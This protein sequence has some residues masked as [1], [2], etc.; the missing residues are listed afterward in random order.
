MTNIALFCI[1]E[2][3]KNWFVQYH[4]FLLAQR[5]IKTLILHSN[6]VSDQ[7]QIFINSYGWLPR[8]QLNRVI[9]QCKLSLNI[10]PVESFSYFTVEALLLGSLPI[11]SPC[12]KDNLQLSGALVVYNTDSPIEI[13]KKI[14][15]LEE[16][17]RERYQELLIS[18]Q[19]SVRSL[20]AAQ[21][22]YLKVMLE[23]LADK[24]L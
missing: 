14:I 18:S 16:L 6:V 3:R 7:P 1:K 20:I 4:G 10:F 9:Q 11:I 17:P 19:N 23:T 12:V 24:K 15:E 22:Q 13:S 5:K 2:A 21:N 8:D